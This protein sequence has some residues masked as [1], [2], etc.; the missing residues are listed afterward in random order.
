M[1][2]RGLIKDLIG[3]FIGFK[4]LLS[5]V[6]PLNP[7]DLFFFGLILVGFCGWFTAERF[8]LFGKN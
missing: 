4:L 8:G 6:F 7:I 1:G 5:F 3:L 2:L